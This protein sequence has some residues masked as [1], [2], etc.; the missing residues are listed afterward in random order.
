MLLWVMS[1]YFPRSEQP[2]SHPPNPGLP[3]AW[4][5]LQGCCQLFPEVLDCAQR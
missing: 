1:P 3:G 4:Q 2:L 5:G